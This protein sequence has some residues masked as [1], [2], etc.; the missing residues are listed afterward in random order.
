MSLILVAPAVD[1]FLRNFQQ[2][3]VVH[4]QLFLEIGPFRCKCFTIFP[5]F[6]FIIIFNSRYDYSI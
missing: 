3:Q 5:H 4:K 1:V 6:L 2:L